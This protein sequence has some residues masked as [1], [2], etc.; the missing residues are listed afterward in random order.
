MRIKRSLIII[1]LSLSFFTIITKGRCEDNPSFRIMT[2]NIRQAVKSD[3]V[4][5]WTN[6]LTLVT[7]LIHYHEP[8][9]FGV[10]EALS[11]QMDDL[12][13]EL[14][15][16]KHIGVGRND[17]E[18]AG[19][20]S[21]IFYRSDRFETIDGNT[22]WLSETPDK[23]GSKGWD[24]A[25]T[26]ICTWACLRDLRTKKE[27]YVYNAHLDNKGQLAR[28]SAVK[29]ILRD[30]D[31]RAGNLPVIVTGDFNSKITSQ[32]YRTMVDHSGFQDSQTIS[33]IPHYGPNLSFN[34]FKFCEMPAPT[35]DFIFVRDGIKVRR[36]AVLTDSF[37]NRYPSDHFP[38]LTEVILP[39]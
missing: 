39:N 32:A 33:E 4:N 29:M 37:E 25:Y 6:R 11:D 31:D 30:I 17:G 28:E 20:F 12:D 5:Y 13:R 27:F 18:R 35:I 1:F 2:Y 21:A 9:I 15:E 14:P 22:F 7:G 10:Q 26:R 24:A 19:E 36:H 23:P 34:G 16:F 3:G 8:D 38:V